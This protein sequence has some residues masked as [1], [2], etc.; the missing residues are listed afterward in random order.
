ML[1]TL[2]SHSK[3]YKLPQNFTATIDRRYFVTGTILCDAWNSKACGRTTG[4]ST[5][6]HRLSPIGDACFRMDLT[7]IHE[8]LF[9]THYRDDEGSNEV[10][11]RKSVHSF[12]NHSA[13]WD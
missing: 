5:L 11:E 7:A 13:P 6:Q 12:S 10:N 3:L 1:G 9:T 8:I 4:S 2:C